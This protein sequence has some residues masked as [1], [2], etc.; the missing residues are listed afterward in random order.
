ME[1]SWAL[2][3]GL[4]GARIY[5][6]LCQSQPQKEGERSQVFMVQPPRSQHRLEMFSGS[7]RVKNR[8]WDSAI[9]FP[10]FCHHD[11]GTSVERWIQEPNPTVSC[12]WQSAS[13]V[14]LVLP[15]PWGV[16]RAGAYLSREPA[17]GWLA[18]ETLPGRTAWRT[19]E[20]QSSACCYVSFIFRHCQSLVQHN[21]ACLCLCR[22]CCITSS[23]LER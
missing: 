7:M 14:C 20:G 21:A 11:A 8:A 1:R 17:P 6:F 9:T 13:Q 19:A 15:E 4:R 2:G 10:F 3:W 18:W 5:S 12:L 22:L 16:G 23:W